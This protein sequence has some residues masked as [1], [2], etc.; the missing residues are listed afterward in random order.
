VECRP[1]MHG[2]MADTVAAMA[3]QPS[4]A[5]DISGPDHKARVRSG[6]QAH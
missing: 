6:A 2:A 3:G 1:Y 5:T 4:F